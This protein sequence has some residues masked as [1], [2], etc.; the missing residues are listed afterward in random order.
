MRRG[1]K[2][3]RPQVKRLS[4]TSR[5]D[6]PD[7]EGTETVLAETARSLLEKEKPARSVGTR[8]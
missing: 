7:E 5:T 3:N 2:L 8:H 6:L 1:L 4:A